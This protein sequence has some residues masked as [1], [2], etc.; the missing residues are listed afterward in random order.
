M[1]AETKT[2]LLIWVLLFFMLGAAVVGQFFILNYHASKADKVKCDFWECEFS[3]TE[4]QIMQNTD[5]YL[6]GQKV[7]CSTLPNKSG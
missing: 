6:N 5:C 4:A 7:N 3:K 2:L 1:D